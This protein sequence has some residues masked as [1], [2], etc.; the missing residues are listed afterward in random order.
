MKMAF[1]RLKASLVFIC[2][3]A[4]IEV[5]AADIELSD[6]ISACSPF[7]QYANGSHSPVTIGVYLDNLPCQQRFISRELKDLFR[8]TTESAV[9]RE[10]LRG[11][12]G[13]VCALFV[14]RYT[15]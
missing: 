8:D 11:S 4:T 9:L 7:L 6:S 14:H 5:V 15:T 10:D 13:N 2:V 3:F 12:L 1:A